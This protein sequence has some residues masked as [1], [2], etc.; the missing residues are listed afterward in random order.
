MMEGKVYETKVQDWQ[1]DKDNLISYVYVCGFKI[2]VDHDKR[3]WYIGAYNETSYMKEFTHIF[4]EGVC[5]QNVPYSQLVS[6]GVK[7]WLEALIEGDRNQCTSGCYSFFKEIN[8]RLSNLG[9]VP[10]G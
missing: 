9:E 3:K 4:L 7:S 8:L 2:G 6:N 10:Y 5:K 1:F